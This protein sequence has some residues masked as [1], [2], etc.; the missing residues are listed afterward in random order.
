[1]NFSPKIN[2][3]YYKNILDNVLVY[4]FGDYNEQFSKIDGEYVFCGDISKN[5]LRIYFRKLIIEELERF[6]TQ[7]SVTN[8]NYYFIIGSCYPKNNI[9]L[10]YNTDNSIPAKIREKLKDLDNK[11][12]LKERDIRLDMDIFNSIF[13]D[14][15]NELF[16]HNKLEKHIGKKKAKNIFFI[17][18]ASLDCYMFFKSV[19]M[20]Y[21]NVNVVNIFK[22]KS[23]D[24]KCN[25]YSFNELIDKYIHKKREIL[26]S[27]D[28][29]YI[30]NEIKQ[31]MD[32]L[33]SGEGIKSNG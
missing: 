18:H 1:M 11:Y 28:M 21:G 31:Y 4:F 33:M 8:P 23:D 19:K 30:I 29:K 6:T 17:K 16:N 26:A 15:F 10:D 14:I 22:E 2:L 3:L 12:I 20:I 24:M 9:L 13:E 27:H 5:K 25:L 32:R 7:F